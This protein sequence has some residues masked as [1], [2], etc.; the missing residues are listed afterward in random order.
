MK[1]RNQT[2]QMKVKLHN[3]ERNIMQISLKNN[4]RI[5]KI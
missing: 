5:I 3:I 4:N 2:S 1:F